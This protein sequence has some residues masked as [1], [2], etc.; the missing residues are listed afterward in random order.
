MPEVCELCRHDIW[1]PSDF[2]TSVKLC[3][4]HMHLSVNS[5]Q[6][7]FID[8]KPNTRAKC[9]NK[10]ACVDSGNRESQIRYKKTWVSTTPKCLQQKK[11]LNKYITME[12]EQNWKAEV[13]Q[14]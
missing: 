1:I 9:L 3:A 10:M 14:N 13:H 2:M 8:A 5:L 7:H 6:S 4:L 11:L 12:L